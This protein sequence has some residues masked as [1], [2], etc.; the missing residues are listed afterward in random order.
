MYLFL[1]LF[2][3]FFSIC[4]GRIAF[5]L[6][7]QQI[8]EYKITHTPL[9]K[10]YDLISAIRRLMRDAPI[11]VE[12]FHIKGHQDDVSEAKLDWFALL[13]IDMDANA[14]AHWTMVHDDDDAPR[15]ELIP[16]EGWPLWIGFE[17][18]TGD[19]RTAI[20]KE[21]HAADLEQ[22][23][24]KR[25]RFP[26]PRPCYDT[27]HRLVGNSSRYAQLYSESTA[28]GDQTSVGSCSCRKM[29]AKEKDVAQ[30][31]MPK[32]WERNDS[33]CAPMP[34]SRALA[35]WHRAMED[36]NTW[37]KNQKT[38][39]GIRAAV[40]KHLTAWQADNPVPPLGGQ[41]FF[42]LP[43][44][45][46]NQ[47][48]VGWQA[49]IEGCPTKGWRESQQQY[50]EY[51]RSRKTG[52]RWLSALIRKLWQVA[53]DMWEHRNSILHDKEK[54]QAALEREDK[55]REEFEEGW[56]KLNRDAKLMFRPGLHRVLQFK[57]GPQKAW[58]ARVEMARQRAAVRQGEME[59][60]EGWRDQWQHLRLYWYKSNMSWK[61]KQLIASKNACTNTKNA[62]PTFS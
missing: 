30:Q 53:W 43:T 25:K 6:W 27:T 39:P 61:T 8:M 37:M 29:D 55:I 50:N 23:W 12:L 3:V 17:K 16:G 7:L 49:F 15:H 57:A 10:H 46:L 58:I 9:R 20:T 1:V 47:N 48:A 24:T 59:D 19:I 34:R 33:A 36:L 4:F 56:D 21:V 28:M 40:I 18:T 44:A 2:L 35:V 11:K 32:M 14:K 42:D 52:L 5:V 51:L 13:N 54:G 22:H 45:I 41:P 62:V 26:A 31:W 60:N 38:H